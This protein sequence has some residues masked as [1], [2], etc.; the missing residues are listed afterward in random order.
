ML[1]ER[2]EFHE[3]KGERGTK[4]TL[5][6]IATKHSINECTFHFWLRRGQIGEEYIK[7]RRPRGPAPGP[8]VA[9]G[10]GPEPQPTSD[11]S[12]DEDDE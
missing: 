10:P 9:T 6:S 5:H 12:D 8:Q 1:A 2:K 4:H 7:E 3:S 11:N